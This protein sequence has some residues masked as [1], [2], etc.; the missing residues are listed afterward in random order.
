MGSDLGGRPGLVQEPSRSGRRHVGGA[1]RLTA[2][3][4]PPWPGATRHPAGRSRRGD[5]AWAFAALGLYVVAAV[6]YFGR[7]ALAAPAGGTIGAGPDVQ[8]FLWGLRWWPFALTHGIDPLVSHAVWAPYG[9]D[10]LWTSSVPLLGVLASPLT[11]ALGPAVSWNVLCV[12]GPALSAWTGYLLCTELT[13]H[14]AAS[15]LGGF[16]F[17]FSSFEVAEGIAHLQMTMALLVP[18]TALVAVRFARGELTGPGLALRVAAL[19]FAQF[20]I[21]PELLA[22]M[23]VMAALAAVAVWLLWPERRLRVRAGCG[24]TLAGAVAVALALAPELVTMLGTLPAAPLTPARSYSTDLLNLFVPTR[25]TALGGSLGA[26]LT[27][28]FAGNLAEQ[29]GYVGVPLLLVS[30]TAVARSWSDRRL[31]LL[32]ILCL[33]AVLLSFGPELRVAGGAVAPL[34]SGLL[35]R[36]PLLDEA[37]PARFALYGALGTGVALSLW[38]A[39]PGGERSRRRGW[40]RGW[41]WIVAALAIACL[42]P[43]PNPALWWRPIPSVVRHDDL[44]R[45]IPAGANVVSLPFW[46]LGDRALFAQAQDGMRFRLDD[47]WLQVIP[48]AYSRVADGRALAATRLTAARVPAFEREL[49]ALHATYAVVWNDAT[50][51]APLHLRSRHADGVLVYRLPGSLC[52]PSG[53]SRT[54]D[55]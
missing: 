14:R 24:W 55:R 15:L 28:R 42:A 47:R 39:R 20:L 23:A 9:A 36:L 52:H 21:S 35:F 32:G 13:G 19:A 3:L 45:L 8:I 53:A 10:V 25:V 17:G 33:A 7:S 38:L 34:P 12:L 40:R 29:V 30:G 11:L 41:R 1:P 2:A 4:E 27:A 51:L 48:L 46:D 6:T 44:A 49:C 26:P 37:L 31:R 43:A 54:G 16:A 18:L 50:L 22:S 5:R